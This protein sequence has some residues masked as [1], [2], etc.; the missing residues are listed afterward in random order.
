MLTLTLT[1]GQIKE[2]EDET[3]QVGGYPMHGKNV[4]RCVKEMT[5]A[6]QAVFGQEKRDGYIGARLSLRALTADTVRSKKEH[7]DICEH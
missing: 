6:S 4:E 5:A 7:A 2:L 1:D 3:M